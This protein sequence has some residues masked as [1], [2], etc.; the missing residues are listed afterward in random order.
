MK[1]PPTA[2]FGAAG[3]FFCLLAQVLHYRLPDPELDNLNRTI[4]KPGRRKHGSIIGSS[5]FRAES[6]VC[7]SARCGKTRTA[8]AGEKLL[9]GLAAS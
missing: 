2:L 4:A 7:G 3:G 5:D 6:F 8:K 9:F 1:K